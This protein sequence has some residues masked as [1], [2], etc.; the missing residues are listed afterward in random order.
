MFLAPTRANPEICPQRRPPIIIPLCS[1]ISCSNIH[2]NCSD[3]TAW[4]KFFAAPRACLNIPDKKGR[5]KVF[6]TL[7]QNGA[8]MHG[9][10]GILLEHSNGKI[11]SFR[12][13]D[14]VNCAIRRNG[15]GQFEVTKQFLKIRSKTK[16]T[17]TTLK[18]C[19]TLKNREKQN[20]QIFARNQQH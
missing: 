12:W 7:D 13:I 3:I 17:S 19:E 9:N 2:R 10:I 14:S 6:L 5:N 20:R 8:K 16:D 18:C 1:L 4:L 15:R 11:G